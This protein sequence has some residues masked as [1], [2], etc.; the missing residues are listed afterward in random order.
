MTY[1][2][3][4]LSDKNSYRIAEKLSANTLTAAKREASR[5]SVFQGTVL[6]IGGEINN[7]EFILNPICQKINGKWVKLDN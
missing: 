1:Y 6:E 5:K 4:E 7:Q 2:F 3:A